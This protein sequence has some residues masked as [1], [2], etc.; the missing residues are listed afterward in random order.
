M[1]DNNSPISLLVKDLETD[2]QSAYEQGVTM[3]QA[4]RLAAK[5]LA[6][7]IK[8]AEALR[9]FDLDAKMKK[10][11]TKAIK[12]AVYLSE[13]Q[14]KEKKPTEAQL[15]A[16]IDSSEIVTQQQEALDTAEVDRDFLQN[17]LNIAK[18]GHIFLRTVARGT[19][20]G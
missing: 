3:E 9:V 15:T 4:E 11:G 12:A 1:I 8:I 17:I 18:D 16:I 14:G 20:S 13:I 19:F 2:I 5:F 6:A 7:Q 10:S